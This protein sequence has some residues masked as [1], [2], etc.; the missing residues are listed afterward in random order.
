MDSLLQDTSL[1]INEEDSLSNVP[2]SDNNI[3]SSLVFQQPPTTNDVAA[4]KKHLKVKLD[5]TTTTTSTSTTGSTMSTETP[6]LTPQLTPLMSSSSTFSTDPNSNNSICNNNNNSS[7]ENE[8]FVGG[9]ARNTT[10]EELQDLF[11]TI[12]NV[13]QVRIM[14]DRSNGENKGYGFVSFAN[15]SNC[16]EAVV[17]FNNKE[18]KGKN[19]RV[20]FSENKRKIFIG[21][22]P[23]ELKKDQLL[24][25]LADHSDGITNVDFLTDPDN[26]SRNRG[27]AFIEYTDY[28]QAEKARKEF[29]QPNFKIGNCNVTVNWAD[30]IQE[31][32]ET[33]MNQV[34]VLYIRNLP[35]SK[36]EEQVR[37]LF[38]EYGVIEKVIIPNNLPGQQRRDF[39]FV[40]FANR[41]EAEA[42]LA[43]H[44]DTPI[45]YQ[46]R[47][48]S[49]S[50]AKP[51][52]K[53]Q[54]AEL[55]VRRLQ[56]TVSRH[57]TTGQQ[58]HHLMSLPHLVPTLPQ[59]MNISIPS[60]A[61]SFLQLPTNSTSNPNSTTNPAS[62]KSAAASYYS[63]LANMGGLY[64]DPY[65][66]Q[67]THLT[68]PHHHNHHGG[69]SSNLG[70]L[71]RYKP[72]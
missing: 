68:N 55:R 71:A 17:Q 19:L 25:I 21:N 39:G 40:H 37:K 66:G 5:P 8:V 11:S 43:R 38:E 46:G 1:F 4:S 60:N 70:Y 41:D 13:K 26:S 3:R 72:Y 61:F 29:S 52:D 47:P 33:I 18:F 23:K 20:K 48:L 30:P 58:A 53:K 7:A 57:H 15:K 59:G 12:G 9:I 49:L 64:I 35:D 6:Q 63:A 54:R 31:P 14:K 42:T 56:R 67:P 32:D 51:I 34:R 45:T 50:F 22:L 36:S 10:E 16:K 62:N 65:T 28:Y 27:F 24:L 2:D 69:Q 44:H